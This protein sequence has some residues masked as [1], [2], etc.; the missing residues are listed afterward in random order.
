MI[1]AADCPSVRHNEQE[2][3]AAKPEP[4]RIP[5]MVRLKT[6]PMPIM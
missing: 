4:T 5:R 3:I 2:T 6:A 1:V